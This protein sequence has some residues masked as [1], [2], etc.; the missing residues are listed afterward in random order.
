MGAG[1]KMIKNPV[2]LDMA[3]AGLNQARCSKIFIISC[4]S[5]EKGVLMIIQHYRTLNGPARQ[6]ELI[7]SHY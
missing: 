5:L 1:S 6:V 3:A 2:A 7:V 4:F